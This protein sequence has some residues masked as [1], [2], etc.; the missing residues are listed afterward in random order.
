MSISQGNAILRSLPSDELDRLSPFFK[1]VPLKAGQRLTAVDEPFNHLWFPEDGAISRLI[2]LLTGETVEAGIVGNDGVL[3]LPLVL[4]ARNGVGVCRVHVDGSALTMAASD[5]DEQVRRRGGPLLDAL[6]LYT[7]LYISVLSQL[8]A[9]HC[10]HR[11]EQRLSRCILELNDYG[12]GGEV[13]VTHD[14]LAEF[15]GVHRPSITYA[16]QALA[17]T[18]SISSERRRIYVLDRASLLDRACECYTVIRATTEREIAR[19]RQA[20]A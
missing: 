15:L 9:C 17:H 12:D 10:L 19:M 1:E 16:L 20:A 8:T 7:N 2:H 3:G 6:M 18:G 5:F 4:G 14:T 11:I 13:R